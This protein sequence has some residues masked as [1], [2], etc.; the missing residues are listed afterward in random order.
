M[1]KKRNFKASTCLKMEDIPIDTF[2]SYFYFIFSI[3]TLS[4]LSLFI[5][6][7]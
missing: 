1:T 6:F 5:Q 2:L 3:F 7:A 4:L